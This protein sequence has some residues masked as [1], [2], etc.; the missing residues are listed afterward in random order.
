MGIVTQT[1]AATDPET[2]ADFGSQLQYSLTTVPDPLTVSPASGTVETGDLIIVGSRISPEPVETN[3]I[4]VYVPLGTEAWQLALDLTGLQSLI[5]LTGWTGTPDPANERI[6][7]KP[8]TGHATLTPEQGITVQLNKLRINR[9]VGTAP[10][11]LALNWRAPGSTSWRTE[12]QTLAIGKF[13]P[14]FY[15]RNLKPDS[16]YIENGDTV[17]LTW[18]RSTN[19]NETYHLLYES[20][21]FDVTDYSTFRV[22]DVSRNTMF[23]LRGRIQAGTGTAERTI[24]TYVTVNR[25][26]LEISSLIAHGT[27][28]AKKGI[29]VG[30]QY[31]LFRTTNSET[32]RKTY[33]ADT[34]GFMTVTLLTLDK[35]DSVGRRVSLWV[36]SPDNASGFLEL[37]TADDGMY[38]PSRRGAT[39]VVPAGQFGFSLVGTG[40]RPSI[41]ARIVWMPLGT[42]SAPPRAQ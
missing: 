15:L 25:P 33:A 35:N 14:G 18:E 8:A 22:D 29:I 12:E 32:I 37:N 30:P 21:E 17:T 23:Y 2:A 42:D 26:D 36:G 7:F 3:Q 28:E 31:E 16:A 9:Q 34:A 24:N 27:V 4:A 10:I 6:L 19:G 13:P 40:S 41:E 20:Q 1:T 39:V 5:N 11:V 38:L